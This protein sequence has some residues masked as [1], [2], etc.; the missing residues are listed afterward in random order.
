MNAY[1]M[2]PTKPVNFVSLVLHLNEGRGHVH[3]YQLAIKETIGLTGWRYNAIL[4]SLQTTKFAQ[5]FSDAQKIDGGIIDRER[6][7]VIRQLKRLKFH[8]FAFSVFN[9]FR[10]LKAQ[11]SHM[12]LED[13][14][15]ILFVEC[16]NPLQLVA[17]QAAIYFQKG[18]WK[19]WLVLRGSKNWGGKKYKLQSWLYVWGT[20][21]CLRFFNLVNKKHEVLLLTD[22]AKLVAPLEVYFSTRVHEIPLPHGND[23]HAQVTSPPNPS[24]GAS[25]QLK[26]WA[27]GVLRPEK[28]EAKIFDLARRGFFTDAEVNL[29][30][31]TELGG[32]SDWHPPNVKLFSL[33]EKLSANEYFDMFNAV[34]L[35]I[36]PYS[37]DMYAESTSGPFVEAICNRTLALVSPGTWMA[38]EYQR[39][40]LSDLISDFDSNVGTQI[41]RVVSDIEVRQ[42][43]RIMS[44][45]YKRFH[46]TTG[47]AKTFKDLVCID[48][49][50][51]DREF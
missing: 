26:I 35:V 41:E 27:P 49:D 47:L 16:F 30:L 21:T 22:S 32:D 19:I 2:T 9:F 36:L 17:I 39:F 12:A 43:L 3:N 15:N 51:L 23:Q 48:I 8:S 13:S 10:Q 7:V 14:E 6:D 45:E 29:Y 40:E 5:D 24:I 33:P 11:I 18:N 34:D 50:K 25:D 38:S 28:G 4:A 46:S 1:Q 42:K 31:Q 37:S 44:D 20:R